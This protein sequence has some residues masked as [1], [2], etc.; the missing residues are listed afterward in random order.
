MCEQTALEIRRNTGK[1][2]ADVGSP[3]NSVRALVGLRGFPGT[4][5]HR[6]QRVPLGLVK[7]VAL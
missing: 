5:G 6:I 1:I 7:V 2:F 4:A 3:E